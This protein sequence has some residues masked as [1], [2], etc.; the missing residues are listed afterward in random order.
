MTRQSITVNLD[1]RSYPIVI[2]SSLLEGGFDL[3]AGIDGPEGGERAECAS[4]VHV[5][6]EQRRSGMAGRRAVPVP[7]KSGDPRRLAAVPPTRTCRQNIA[8]YPAHCSGAGR[9]YWVPD[10]G[11]I[12]TRRA[13]RRLS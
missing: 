2:G 1:E 4:P 8:R 13:L 12:D 9:C 5:R 11:L 10:R 7:A 3:A 6:C